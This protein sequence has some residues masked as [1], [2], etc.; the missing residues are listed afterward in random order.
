[1]VAA[2]PAV[3]KPVKKEANAFSV[4]A[5]LDSEERLCRRRRVETVPVSGEAAASLC[6]VCSAI[7]PMSSPAPSTFPP[8]PCARVLE[9]TRGRQAEAC[10]WLV[11]SNALLRGARTRTEQVS[12]S[13]N[14]PGSQQLPP[15]GAALSPS[16]HAQQLPRPTPRGRRGGSGL[17]P[18]G[19]LAAAPSGGQS[20]RRVREE[21]GVLGA[22]L[23]LP[24]SR[25]GR[26]SPARTLSIPRV[27]RLCSPRSAPA[28]TR[29]QVGREGARRTGN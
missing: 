26:A 7:D 2:V 19:G 25:P 4:R 1:M 21:P 14:E 12:R 6:G 23:P 9:V 11:S 10:A 27:S 5:H 20:W 18:N 29:E 3:S 13:K 22:P 28:R 8:T 15:S 24:S 16:A 17:R